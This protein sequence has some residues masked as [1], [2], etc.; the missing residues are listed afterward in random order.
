VFGQ[1]TTGATVGDDE[2]SGRRRGE[3]SRG[4]EKE[5][6]ELH[7]VRKAWHQPT[8]GLSPAR[9]HQ[10]VE[11]ELVARWPSV[12]ALKAMVRRQQT[13]IVAKTPPQPQ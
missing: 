8:G 10:P 12:I 9:A 5:G 3:S 7:R 13:I 11:A 2:R 4:G 6:G 1:V